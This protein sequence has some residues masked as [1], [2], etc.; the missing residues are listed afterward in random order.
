LSSLNCII[1]AL[2]ENKTENMN[3]PHVT[4]SQVKDVRI[5][6]LVGG[7][8]LVNFISDDAKHSS[9]VFKLAAAQ[10]RPLCSDNMIDVQTAP[11]AADAALQQQ[12]VRIKRFSRR[13]V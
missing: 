6:K 7:S 5:S 10:R 13:P 11:A 8:M 3:I 4:G 2:D 1:G 9:P 12:G